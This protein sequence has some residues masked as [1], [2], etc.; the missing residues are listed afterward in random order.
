V[1]ALRGGAADV[2]GALLAYLVAASA[3]NAF[4]G[5]RQEFLELGVLLAMA[6]SASARRTLPEQDRSGLQA[7]LD[8]VRPAPVPGAAFARTA[9]DG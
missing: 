1:S 3:Y 2:A 4:E 6:L 7:R 8:R 5:G 9:A